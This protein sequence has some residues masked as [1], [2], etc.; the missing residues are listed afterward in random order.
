MSSWLGCCPQS[1]G[2]SRVPPLL[3]GLDSDGQTLS[4]VGSEGGKGRIMGEDHSLAPGRPGCP[5]KSESLKAR[6]SRDFFFF[7]NLT[8]EEHQEK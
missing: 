7:F 8:T 5:M 1:E 4:E 2:Q 3:L 6:G